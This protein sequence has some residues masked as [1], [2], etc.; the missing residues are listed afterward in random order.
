MDS[1]KRFD[2]II[3]VQV[4]PQNLSKTDI[5]CGCTCPLQVSALWYL[6][7]ETISA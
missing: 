3:D 4:G 7:D 2:K 5:L 1:D 6:Q